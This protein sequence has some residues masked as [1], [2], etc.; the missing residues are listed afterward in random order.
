MGVR[1]LFEVSLFVL[2]VDFF[3][4]V[5]CLFKCFGP[6]TMGS[7]LLMGANN[8]AATRTPASLFT[9]AAVLFAF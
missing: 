5:Q 9:L 1:L 8:G 4:L 2:L 7:D 6:R 3:E